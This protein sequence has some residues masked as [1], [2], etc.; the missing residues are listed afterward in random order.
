M[1][2]RRKS[3][4]VK[5]GKLYIGGDAPITVQSMTTTDTKDTKATIEQIHGLEEIGCDIVRVSA[6]TMEA[7]KALKEIK[8]NIGIPL[9][10]DIH[11]DYRIALEAVKYMDKFLKQW[12]R[13]QCAMS[14]F[15]RALIFMIRL[16]H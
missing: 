5:V 10:V 6:P 14:G 2:Q 12:L 9:V 7:A 8:E 1:L 4:K 16:S 13:A 3:R 11:F 15:L